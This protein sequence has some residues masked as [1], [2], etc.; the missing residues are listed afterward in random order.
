MDLKDI[1]RARVKAVTVIKTTVIHIVPRILDRVSKVIKFEN[2]LSIKQKKV[3]RQHYRIP[4][5]TLSQI[6]EKYK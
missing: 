1:I 3:L 6:W 5:E 4:Q 2:L